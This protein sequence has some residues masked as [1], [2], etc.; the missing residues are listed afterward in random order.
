M[1]FK[2]GKVTMYNQAGIPAH[3]WTFKDAWV[4]EYGIDDFDASSAS[5]LKEKI[6]IV[7]GELTHDS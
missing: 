4:S 3:S 5:P 7:F 6:T 2:N 1:K